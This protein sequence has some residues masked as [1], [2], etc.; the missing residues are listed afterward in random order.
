[1]FCCRSGG[2]AV[3]EVRFVTTVN[4][5]TM[6]LD[7]TGRMDGLGTSHYGLIRLLHYSREALADL[8][9]DQI[10]KKWGLFAFRGVSLE[11]L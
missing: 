10:G 1:M 4:L 9:T 7:W 5:E 3:E 6:G 11:Q 8:T 2:G